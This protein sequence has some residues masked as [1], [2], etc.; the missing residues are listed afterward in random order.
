V[1]IIL[2]EGLGDTAHEYNTH[3][4]AAELGNWLQFGLQ[5]GLHFCLFCL[6]YWLKGLDL[7]FVDILDKSE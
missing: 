3:L 6:V 1:F 7:K 5:F 4:Q 2:L